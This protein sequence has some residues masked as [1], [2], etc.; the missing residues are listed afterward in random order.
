[1]DVNINR[2][3]I[4]DDQERIISAIIDTA[5]EQITDAGKESATRGFNV[6]CTTGFIPAIIIVIIAYIV[7]KTWLAAIITGILMVMALIGYA[8]LVALIARSKAMDR[9]FITEVK[10]GIDKTLLETGIS[11]DEFNRF[12][13]ENLSNSASLYQYLPKSENATGKQKAKF[14]FLTKWFR[15][16]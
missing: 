5:E 4:S 7:T 11:Q 6:G 16:K 12:A 3:W 10:P 1:M 13:I 9:V 8:N 2:N 15:T 14:R